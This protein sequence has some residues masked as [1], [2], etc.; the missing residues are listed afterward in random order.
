MKKI[1]YLIL[2]FLTVNLGACTIPT[3]AK[4]NEIQSFTREEKKKKGAFG[5]NKTTETIRD[6]R[7]NEMYPEDITAAKEEVEKYIA[8]HPDLSEEIK[9]NLRGLKVAPG[10]SKEEVEL[11]LGE[12]DK[13]SKNKDLWIYRISRIRAF[14][15]FIFPVFFAHEGYYLRFKDNKLLAIERHYPEQTIHQASAPGLI[16]K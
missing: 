3:A 15:V 16:N 6:F 12:P 8:A 10:E 9:N 1:Q 13:I 7:Q 5:T 11:L 2:V 4:Y 14:T